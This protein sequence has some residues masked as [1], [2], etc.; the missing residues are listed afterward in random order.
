MGASASQVFIWMRYKAI[1]VEI[2]CL[3]TEP[4]LVL[5]ADRE[6]SNNVL[7]QLCT[8]RSKYMG[9]CRRGPIPLARLP[10]VMLATARSNAVWTS[11]RGVVKRDTSSRFPNEHFL[12][13]AGQHGLS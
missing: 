5:I 9:I 3:A 10:F 2:F 6:Y 11:C 12:T 4:V 7:Q 1:E 13:A 8:G